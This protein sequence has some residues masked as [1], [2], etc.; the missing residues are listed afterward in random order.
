M[1]G[2]SH[3]KTIKRTKE[4]GDAQKSRLFS[5]FANELT[6]LART[7]GGDLTGNPRLRVVVEKAKEAHMP[8]D[9]IE[10]AIKRGTGELKGSQLEELLIEAYGPGGFAM[11][12]EAITDSKNRTLGEIKQILSRHNAKLVG[13]GGVRWMF[14]KQGGEWVAKPE[15]EIAISEQDQKAANLLFEALDENDATQEVYSNLKEAA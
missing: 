10:R 8:S 9:N 5:K 1:S 3:F 14:D 4:L 13:E 15:M 11:L 7:G 6:V 2:H 12:V